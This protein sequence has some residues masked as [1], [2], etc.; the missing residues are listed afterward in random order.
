MTVQ[1]AVR[2]TQ[3]SPAALNRDRA[4]IEL[5]LAA[6]RQN[7]RFLQSCLAP[8][9]RLMPA[10]KAN[11]YGHGASQIAAALNALGIDAFCVASVREGV[12]LRRAGIHGEILILGYT[13]PALFPALEKYRLTQTVVD[14]A[15]ARR[16][17]AYGTPLPVHIGIDTG[18][19]RLGEPWTHT[20]A[21]RQMLCMKNLIPQGIFTHLCACDSKKPEAVSYTR[22][23][24]T[25]FF[26]LLDRLKAQNCPIP[27]IHLLSS[28]GVLSY[29]EYS[30]DYARVGLALYGVLNEDPKGCALR[31]VLS[32][33]AR[34]ASVRTLR[35]GEHAGY[36]MAFTARRKTT[37]AT[38]T[39]GYADGLPSAISGRGQ[40][41]LHGQYAPII[42]RVCMDQT[43]VD[44]TDIAGV[45]AGDTVT[46]IGTCGKNT[47]SCAEVARQC[48]TIPNEILS[49]LGSRLCRISVG[50]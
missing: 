49:R 4:W 33:K 40:V 29:P 44:V 28:Y 38:V 39:I 24:A 26:R 15:Y 16:L 23:Q 2:P 14:Y 21:I 20:S 30:A 37:L 42:G 19:H 25:A 13:H 35:P 5:D 45:K 46:V 27:K 17:N 31:P 48:G 3:K 6:L 36:G 43:M 50:E 47:I 1:A 41:L 11:A 18:M 10:V 9:C 34:V 8:G 22:R 12:A 7:V 32:L